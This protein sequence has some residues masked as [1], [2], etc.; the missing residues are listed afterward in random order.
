MSQSQAQAVITKF[1]NGYLLRNGRLETGDL[2]ISSE[3]GRI[4]NSQSTFYASHIKPDVTIDLG[5]KLLSPGLIDVQLNGGHGFDFSIPD[6]DFE[7]KLED[8]NRRF[9][10]AGV[11]SYLPTVISANPDVYQSG[12]ESL[13]AH[14][15]GPFLA[16]CRNGIHNKTVLQHAETW[17][18]IQR[19]YGADNLSNGTVR[20]V[21]AAPEIANMINLI[22]E[23]TSRG[24]VFSIGHSDAD[25]A[26]ASSA[27]IHGATMVTHMFNAMRPFG[28]RDPGIFGLLGSAPSRPSTPISSR[29]SSHPSSPTLHSAQKRSSTPRSSL[30]ITS[31]IS[32]D[33]TNVLC[34]SPTLTTHLH[35]PTLPDRASLRP[36]FG[37]IS[38][39]VHL[40]PASLKIAYTSFPAG[41]ILVTDALSFAGLPDGEYPWTNGTTIIKKGPE[42]RGKDTGRLAGVAISLIECVNNF[43]RFT[44]VPVGEALE[45]VTSRPARML[46]VEDRKGG[47]E[48][49]MDADLIVLGGLGEGAELDGEGDL[50]V[51]AVWKFGVRLS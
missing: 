24:I 16:P 34:D 19:V 28:H 37:L 48:A 6:D 51:E 39:G 38:D 44:G 35:K 23:F 18:D 12:A 13:G 30:S 29:P 32:E 15:E 4:L 1:V 41:A 2:W 47:L 25:L 27:V 36:Y 11:T 40:S 3:T 22:P 10:K 26:Q 14:V 46:G 31:S 33:D 43:R 9:A 42:I 50:R 45:T 21:T 49:G 20:K 17:S 7:K 8:T 5:G